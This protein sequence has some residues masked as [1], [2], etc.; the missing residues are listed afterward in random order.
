VLGYA[1]DPTQDAKS[2]VGRE[3]WVVAGNQRRK[4]VAMR[5][6]LITEEFYGVRGN[7][8]LYP[9]GIFVL[10]R[11][12]RKKNTPVRRYRHAQ[13]LLQQLC[14]GGFFLILHYDQQMHNYFTNYHT[15]TC[16]DTIVSSSDSL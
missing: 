1:F 7:I 14:G 13:N 11:E 16:F 2:L 10:F 5:L 6:T 8:N 15:A 12:R 3:F 9:P 4:L